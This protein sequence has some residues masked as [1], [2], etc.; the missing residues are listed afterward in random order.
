MII[1]MSIAKVS[2]VELMNVTDLLEK[3]DYKKRQELELRAGY[4]NVFNENWFYEL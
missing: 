1:F 3:F 4:G 2:C